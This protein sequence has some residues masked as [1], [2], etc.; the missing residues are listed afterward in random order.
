[1]NLLI[2]HLGYEVD[3]YKS[4]V[5]MVDQPLAQLQ[6]QIINEASQ[7]VFSGDLTAYDEVDNWQKGQ[8]YVA[9]FSQIG[10]PGHYRFVVNGQRSHLFQ[11]KN[12][13]YQHYLDPVLAYINQNRC[14]GANDAKDAQA[15]FV[16]GRDDVVDVSG[17]WYD[18]SGDWSKYLSHLSF[19]NYMNPQ[20]IPMVQWSLLDLVAAQP[21][22]HKAKDEAIFGA[23]S[24]LKLQ[25]SEGYFYMTIFDKWSK[26]A[27]QRE[28]CA[29]KTQQG[30]KTEEWQAAFRQGGGLSIAA[31]ARSARQLKDPRYLA[32]AVK[33]FAHLQVHN[34]QYCDNRQE[35][36]I[37][38]YCALMAAVELYR[39]TNEPQYQDAAKVRVANLLARFSRDANY[40]G[41]LRADD[42][43]E[44][45]FSHA[46]EEGFPAIAL[47]H[48]YQHIE[49]QNEIKSALAQWFAF[50][51]TISFEVSNPFG[52]VR[53]YV[54]PLSSEKR[55]Q[56]FFVH[57]KK[58][59]KMS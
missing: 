18:A 30:I 38:D 29:Y 41:W 40:T 16:S 20:Q 50:W 35:N 48:F 42:A 6:F 4:A 25:D 31:L 52:Y 17:A 14:Q 13:M 34:V 55:A 49:P 27:Q 12:D 46:V 36:I 28:I 58:L 59:H 1:M 2:N 26:D 19:A 5:V 37:D 9:E 22:N 47:M 15:K 23:D 39:S 7:V 10:S 21:D 8:F 57:E 43:G 33:G 44:R 11:V 53:H 56:F 51:Q 32:A 54:K 24:L 45:P 3:G